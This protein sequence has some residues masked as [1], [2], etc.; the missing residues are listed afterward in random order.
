MCAFCRQTGPFLAA[1]CS[2]HLASFCKPG[3]CSRLNSKADKLADHCWQNA[4]HGAARLQE[5]RL[6]FGKISLLQQQIQCNVP[7]SGNLLFCFMGPRGGTPTLTLSAVLLYLED[8]MHVVLN[9]HAKQ[10]CE[11][12]YW[13]LDHFPEPWEDPKNGSTLGF[14]SLHHRTC[15]CRV[16]NWGFYFL[17]PP[18]ALGVGS[19]QGCWN[20]GACE[21]SW[22]LTARRQQRPQLTTITIIFVGSYYKALYIY[23]TYR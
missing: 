5:E 4:G 20:F 22:P 23:I 15:Y 7:R 16:Q 13:R 3:C 10:T 2:W 21:S 1:R 17:D 6:K 18:R 9:L 14:D 11:R 19:V 12:S 8:C